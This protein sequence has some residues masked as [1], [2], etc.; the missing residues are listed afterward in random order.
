MNVIVGNV[1]NKNKLV[2]ALYWEFVCQIVNRSLVSP[3]RMSMAAHVVYFAPTSLVKR[4]LLFVLVQQ[5]WANESAFSQTR[6]SC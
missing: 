6:A 3:E 5:S 2:S 1:N 4:R